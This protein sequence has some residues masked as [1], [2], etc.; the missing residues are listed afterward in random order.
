VLQ[1]IPQGVELAGVHVGAAVGHAAQGRHLE[2]PLLLVRARFEEAQGAA[3]LGPRIA[4]GAKAVELVRQHLFGTAGATGI[5]GQARPLRHA[6]VVE[7]VVR[8]QGAVVAGDA[9]RLAHEQPESGLLL[10]RKL[11]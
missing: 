9:V 2:L 7:L 5:G 10:G 4:P 6:G 11:L 8:Q 1:D 3:V